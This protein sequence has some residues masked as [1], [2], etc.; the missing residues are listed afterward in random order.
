MKTY[1]VFVGR[2]VGIFDKWEDCKNQVDGFK[3][4]IFKGFKDEII[5][6]KE[7]DKFTKQFSSKGEPDLKYPKPT[8]GICSDASFSSKTKVLEYRVVNISDSRVLHQN[9]FEKLENATNLGEFF[10]LV[11]AVKYVI[12][13]QLD[14]PIFCDSVT[15]I[16]WVNNKKAKTSCTDKTMM[17]RIEQAEIYLKSI[18]LPLIFKWQTKLW[19]EIPADY[20]R[21]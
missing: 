10:A 9:R 17:W 19:G 7:F 11:R 3:G 13:N 18:T 15:A 5:A 6:K 14:T 16:S 12:D 4:A 1:V 20:G 21:K 2:K 8:R